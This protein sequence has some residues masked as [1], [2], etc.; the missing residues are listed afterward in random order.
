MSSDQQSPARTLTLWVNL[1]LGNYFSSLNFTILMSEIRIV[2][3]MV[4]MVMMMI[5][6]LD[7]FLHQHVALSLGDGRASL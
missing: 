3:M 6:G 5:H 4:I 7:H 2:V 1:N